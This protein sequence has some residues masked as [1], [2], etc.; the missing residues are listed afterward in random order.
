MKRQD[1]TYR[2][3]VTSI[4]GLVQRVATHLLTKG[5]YFFVQ[6]HVP[7]GK[8]P[9]ALDQKLLSR[10]D[11]VKTEGAR[12]WR[13][14]QGLANI[15]Y[16]RFGRAWYLL[17]THGDHFIRAGEAKNLRDAR[18]A[19]IQLGPYSVYVKARTLP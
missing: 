15:Q 12:Y 16:V 14:T 1:T 9:R 11:V 4:E 2:Y 18:K 6:G 10:Y 13:K 3:E 17:A 8:D 19:P 7:E 5:Y